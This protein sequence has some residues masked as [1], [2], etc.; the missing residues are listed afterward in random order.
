MTEQPPAARPRARMIAVL[1][2]AFMV[3]LSWSWSRASHEASGAAT[4]RVTS[5]G[6]KGTRSQGARLA[7]PISG[8]AVRQQQLTALRKTCTPTNRRTAPAGSPAVPP[9]LDRLD[10]IHDAVHP[11]DRGLVGRRAREV[12]PGGLHQLVGIVRAAG[13]DE[14]QVALAGARLALQYPVG[15]ER[16]RRDRGR[17]LED[18]ERVIEVRDVGPFDGVQ[19]VDL[20]HAFALAVVAAQ[21]LAVHL[22]EPLA[23]ERLALVDP[24]VNLALELGEHRL[25][26]E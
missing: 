14:L 17:V 18:V 9:G 11:R 4:V 26:E 3:L 7:G 24:R 13:A 23:T 10:F 22:G 25:A 6:R 19:V 12:D 21:D 16:A 2:S 1:F 20:H 15:K 8:K 5:I